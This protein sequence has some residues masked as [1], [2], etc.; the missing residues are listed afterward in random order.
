M[1][2]YIISLMFM[3]TVQSK[4]DVYFS[5]Q[6]CSVVSSQNEVDISVHTDMTDIFVARPVGLFAEQMM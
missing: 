5:G 1:L 3:I 4:I 2:L 6:I